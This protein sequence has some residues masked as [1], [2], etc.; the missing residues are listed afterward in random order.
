MGTLSCDPEKIEARKSVAHTRV[1]DQI[2]LFKHSYRSKSSSR[3]SKLLLKR[4][5]IGPQGK[6]K[7]KMVCKASPIATKF[8]TK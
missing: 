2:Q 3:R 5:K 8:P 6:G 1:I 4:S 7:G